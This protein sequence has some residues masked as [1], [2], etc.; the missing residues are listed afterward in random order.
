MPAQPHTAMCPSSLQD[1]HD[2][3]YIVFLSSCTCKGAPSV[4]S[5]MSR[6]MQGAGPWESQ[7]EQLLKAG[8]E[9]CMLYCCR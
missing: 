1:S 9:C 5:L 7:R 4:T 8:K 2:D 6:G 3:R